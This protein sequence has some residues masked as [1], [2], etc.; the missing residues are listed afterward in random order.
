MSAGARFAIRLREKLA[1]EDYAPNTV[2]RTL[3]DCRQ[4]DEWLEGT[5]GAPLDRD[6][7]Q[8]VSVD[9][10]DWRSWLVRQ[11]MTPG[12]VR[13]KFASLRLG[14]Q[15]MCPDLLARLRFPKLPQERVDAPSGFTRSERN[16]I[17]R[18]CDAMSPRDAAIVKLLLMTGAR[19]SSVANAR[20]SGVRIGQR[21]G[22]IEYTGKGNKRYT[23][24]L[25]VEARAA[26]SAWLAV[27]PKVAGDMLF[28]AER[29]PHGAISRWVVHQVWAAL[30]R[31]VP[32]E[33]AA[34]IKG[35]H[36]ARHDL[37]RRL[38][39]GDEGARPPVPLG[40]VAAILAHADVRVTA[41]IYA[42]PSRESLARALEQIGGGDE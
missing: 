10:A 28:V 35:P 38:L 42:R 11:R 34:K 25:N 24:P 2:A 6:A 1:L 30:K 5:T 15:L 17:L 19:A 39:S 13:R 31:H 23:V 41:G 18:A 37:A 14:F 20:L 7:P 3:T 27:R 22:S 4:F 12:T 40:D 36:Q 16:A 29:S 9:L 21:S 26:L 32:A 33:L 8:V